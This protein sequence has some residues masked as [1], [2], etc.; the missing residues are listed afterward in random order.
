MNCM[1]FKYETG[2]ATLVQF[3]ISSLFILVTQTGSSVNGCLKKG[4]DCVNNLIV[5][6]VFFT[7]VSIVFGFIWLVG[8]TAQDRRSRRLALLLICMQGFLGLLALFSLK[9]NLHS[10]NTPGIIGS[11]GLLLLSAWILTV[12]FRL[13]RAKGGRVVARQTGRRRRRHPTTDL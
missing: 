6:I 4:N 10:H 5:S 2:V 9:L 3:I 1:R 13:V 7:V 8:Y 12:A 11:V